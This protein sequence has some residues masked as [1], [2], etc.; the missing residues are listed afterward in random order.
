MCASAGFGG[1]DE[2]TETY[3]DVAP[4][5]TGQRVQQGER[6]EERFGKGESKKSQCF[7][8]VSFH[9]EWAKRLIL[10][11]PRP[12]PGSVGSTIRGAGVDNFEAPGGFFSNVAELTEPPQ[13]LVAEKMI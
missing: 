7:R 12:S 8:F 5:N 10:K 4:Q 1:G 13:W 3:V 6:R 11:S 9:F 2:R